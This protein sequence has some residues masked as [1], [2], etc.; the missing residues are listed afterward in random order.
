MDEAKLKKQLNYLLS[1]GLDSLKT[2]NPRSALIKFQEI[3]DHK[4]DNANILNFIGICH[5]QLKNYEKALLY[6]SKAIS[7]NK[8]EVGFYLN[9]GNVYKDLKN[10]KK[11]LEVYLACLEINKAAPDLLYNIGILYENQHKYKEALIYY[12]KTIELEPLNKFA[13]NNTA[14]V[15]KELSLFN[16]AAKLY[17]KAINIDQNYAQ[18][19]FN[20]GL[21]LLLTS[22]SRLGWEKY[23]YREGKIKTLKIINNVEKWSGS[24][25]KNKKL[26]IIC[27]QGIGDSILFIRYVK[28]IKK[29]QSKIYL[30]I[31]ENLISLFENIAEIDEIFINEEDLPSIDYYIPLMSLPFIFRNDKF[32]PPVYNFLK[33][34]IKNNKDW[35]NKI[36]KNTKIKIGIVW[37]GD[38]INN[39]YNFKRSINLRMFQSILE[40]KEIEFI[41]LQ[42]DYGRDQI[43]DN[44]L[45]NLVTD[46]YG[47][48]DQKPFED[49]IPII[50]CLDMVISIDTSL[51]HI[52]ATMEKETWILIPK[53][54][55]FRWGLESDKAIWYNKATLY[56]QNKIN[57]W[58]DVF[59]KIKK[60]LIKKY[61]LN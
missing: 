18:A 60:D 28:K 33:Y 21:L 34:K 42:K 1:E 11:A 56:R 61:N 6:I 41:S 25:I 44:K 29:S 39:K 24:N 9:L 51:A 14:N 45:Q 5:S 7:I 2:N 27:E 40:L 43:N 58:S 37:Q 20:L 13:L 47:K 36:N 59:K 22:N 30:L 55:D 57:D 32:V 17:K 23:E 38:K 49:T 16:E 31:K 50:D 12:K 48:I 53:V 3:L 54:P 52:A 46:F 15:S 8:K 26:L 4:P 10:F 35:K 19:H